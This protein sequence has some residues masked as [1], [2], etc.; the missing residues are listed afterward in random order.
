MKKF[1]IAF[2]L[3]LPTCI[4]G[5]TIT[6]ND[7][8]YDIN[9]KNI[10]NTSFVQL[11]EVADILS[12]DISWD[13]TDKSIVVSNDINSVTLYINQN[14]MLTNNGIIDISNSPSIIEDKTYLPLRIIAE[15]FQYEVGYKDGV[16]ILKNHETL[17]SYI[18][19][20]MI[21]YDYI[22]TA[23]IKQISKDEIQDKKNKCE[24][25]LRRGETV[26]GGLFA[27]VRADNILKDII[28]V[29]EMRDVN[30]KEIQS[31]KEKIEEKVTE[32][33]SF[34]KVK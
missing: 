3:L 13:K 7:T 6:M 21:M 8:N 32:L 12:L 23:D 26:E 16:V 30:N 4:Y 11:R 2:L 5:Q 24:D 22:M 9:T 27:V 20:T 29:L 31:A 14:K 18:K 1:L 25:L 10:N 34:Y 19:Q 17:Y 15:Q 33:N 28:G